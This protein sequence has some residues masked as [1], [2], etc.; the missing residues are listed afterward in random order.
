MVYPS[1][2]PFVGDLIC[3]PVLISILADNE[4]KVITV[5]VELASGHTLCPT[6]APMAGP[7]GV[8]PY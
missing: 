1:G 4:V 3:I 5:S 7:Q 6:L 2:L 8:A